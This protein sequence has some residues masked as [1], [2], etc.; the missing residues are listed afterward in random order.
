MNLIPEGKGSIQSANRAK[1]AA[2]TIQILFD[3]LTSVG[4]FGFKS[5]ERLST[6]DA[7][8]GE[9]IHNFIKSV[10]SGFTEEDRKSAETVSK[11]MNSFTGI[12]LGFSIA[13]GIITL[14]VKYNK[15]TDIGIGIIIMGVFTAFA[16]GVLKLFSNKKLQ[17]NAKDS[18]ISLGLFTLVLLGLTA[19]LAATVSLAQNYSVEELLIAGGIIAGMSAILVGMTWLMKLI[20][21]NLSVKDMVKN[22]LVLGGMLIIL[23]GLTLIT[24]AVLDLADRV[25][26]MEQG[27]IWSTYGLMMAMIGGLLVISGLL[28]LSKAVAGTI[29]LGGAVLLEM[30]I[31][32]NKMTE[33]TNAYID[34]VLRLNEIP[35]SMFDLGVKLGTRVIKDMITLSS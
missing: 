18:M 6:L 28:G 32:L 17:T 14:I 21:N 24:S 4:Y 13:L 35:E 19:V 2:E 31:I 11:L 27:D 16:W 23:G 3:A 15:L 5:I 1:L 26:G 9:N 7:K 22:A 33:V 25:S 29:A 8:K 12:L 34:L 30:V 10:I 20:N